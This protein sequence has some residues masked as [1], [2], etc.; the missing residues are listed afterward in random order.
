MY[1]IPY[2]GKLLNGASGR[3]PEIHINDESILVKLYA[4]MRTCISL[5]NRRYPLGNFNFIYFSM[6]EKSSVRKFTTSI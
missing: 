3:L 2:K 1:S 4:Y 5:Q 6:K